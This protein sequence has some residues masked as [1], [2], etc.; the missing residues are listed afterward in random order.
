MTTYGLNIYLYVCK[1]RTTCIKSAS[2]W[3]PPKKFMT[4]KMAAKGDN[5]SLTTELFRAIQNFPMRYPYRGMVQY[6]STNSKLS[7]K[8]F[9]SM[10]V[11]KQFWIDTRNCRRERKINKQCVFELFGAISQETA[12]EVRANLVERVRLDPLY[13]KRVGHVIMG[14]QKCTLSDWC[15]AMENT[16]T[17]A[18]ELAIFALSKIYQRHTVIFNASKPWTTLEPDGEMLESELYE[19]CQIHLAYI[20][21]HRYATLHRKPFIEASAPQSLRSMLEPMRVRKVSKRSCQKEAMDLSVRRSADSSY[22]ME[23]GTKLSLTLS[24]NEGENNVSVNPKGD[25]MEN[26]LQDMSENVHLESLKDVSSQIVTPE[27]QRYI[28]ALEYIRQTRSEVKLVKMKPSVVDFY[29]QK[30]MSPKGDNSNAESPSLPARQSRA[31]RPVRKCTST[32]TKYTDGD[33]IDSD[34]DID[35]TKGSGRE[36]KRSKPNAS[37]PSASRVASQNKRSAN[38]ASSLPSSVRTYARSD[39]PVYSEQLTEPSD[40]GY[41]SSSG[42]S[43]SSHPYLSEGDSSD[44]FYGFDE[45][46]IEPETKKGTGKLY[47]VHFGLR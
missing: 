34:N 24:N 38:P 19:H 7:I 33:Y 8:A 31:G 12:S 22:D 14:F 44:T 5:G 6:I 43:G 9:N 13:Y 35:F 3:F 41:E 23:Q 20:G 26:D 40:N 21:K 27:C 16:S 11:S 28:D 10:D 36:P 2:T 17:S 37:G 4:S 29:L 42:S 18:D 32:V 45:T 25:N 39:S 1:T 46:D 47:T 30:N 15:N